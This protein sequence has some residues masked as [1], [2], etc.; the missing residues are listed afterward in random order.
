MNRKVGSKI[1][2]ERERKGWRIKK[3]RDGKRKQ[4]I[5]IERKEAR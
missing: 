4:L 5:E 3:E 1:D 2:R